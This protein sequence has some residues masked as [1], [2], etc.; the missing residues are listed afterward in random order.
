RRSRPARKLGADCDAPVCTS[1]DGKLPVERADP[2]L[3][4]GGVVDSRARLDLDTQYAVGP[5]PS[6]EGRTVGSPHGLQNDRV[7]SALDRGSETSI[8]QPSDLDRNAGLLRERLDRG[9]EPFVG[10]NRTKD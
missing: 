6:N 2:V 4:P 5:L 7:G 3:E 10:E 9:R 1:L 8:R